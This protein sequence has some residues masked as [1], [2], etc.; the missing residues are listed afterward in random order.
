MNNEL[1]KRLEDIS[2]ELGGVIRF[3]NLYNAS[4]KRMKRITITYYEDQKTND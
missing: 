4:G 3:Q 2:E 1:M